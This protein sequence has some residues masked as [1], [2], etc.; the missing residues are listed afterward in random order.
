MSASWFG[1]LLISLLDIALLPVTAILLPR[2]MMGDVTGQVHTRRLP[3]RHPLS[4][5]DYRAPVDRRRIRR[6]CR[7][8]PR[9]KPKHRLLT[10]RAIHRRLA[11]VNGPPECGLIPF[12][13]PV[14]DELT[15][16]RTRFIRRHGTLPSRAETRHQPRPFRPDHSKLAY[17]DGFL[18]V[19]SYSLSLQPARQATQVGP[20]P[21]RSCRCQRRKPS[22]GS[23]NR[24]YVSSLL[25]WTYSAAPFT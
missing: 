14:Q 24:R 6:R 22:A 12:I 20:W 17:G 4:G 7:D 8:V 3:N 25:P 2:R 1:H 21:A 5:Q 13:V 15:A 9:L 23:F 10:A 16:M 11:A 19:N 18:R